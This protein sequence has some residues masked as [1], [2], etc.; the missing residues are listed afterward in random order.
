MDVTKP[1]KT[2]IY[3]YIWFGTMDVAKPCEFKN[4]GEMDVTKPLSFDTPF[5]VGRGP[6]KEDM[7]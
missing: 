4:F 7:V 3:I 1:K 5:L 6:I 2:Y